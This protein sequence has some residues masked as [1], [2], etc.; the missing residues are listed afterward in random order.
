VIT[1][2]GG[3]Q[4]E[5]PPDRKPGKPPVSVSQNRTECAY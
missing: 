5:S 2:E 3:T 4:T 1:R